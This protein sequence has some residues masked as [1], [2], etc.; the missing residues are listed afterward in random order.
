LDRLTATRVAVW[1]SMGMAVL[2]GLGGV[3]I[4]HNPW[5]L[6][7]GLFLIWAGHQELRAL[8]LRQQGLRQQARAEMLEPQ[9][10]HTEAPA[11]N[12]G[13]QPRSAVTVY[14]W[15][16]RTRQWIAQGVIPAHNFTDYA[17]RT[18]ATRRPL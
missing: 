8:E 11:G 18:D 7:V 2:F 6:L 4:L 16:A 10:F 15:D 1:V 5:L 9:C 3:F 17:D 14:I 13:D 12:V